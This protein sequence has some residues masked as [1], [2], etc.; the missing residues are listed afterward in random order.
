MRHAITEQIEAINEL[1]KIVARSAGEAMALPQPRVASAGASL[2]P[3]TGP[4]VAP[5]PRRPASPRPAA[6]QPEPTPAATP[7]GEARCGRAAP[8][9]GAVRQADRRQGCRDDRP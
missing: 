5:A 8:V 2:P 4:S 1:S 9:R 3:A 6:K 7:G